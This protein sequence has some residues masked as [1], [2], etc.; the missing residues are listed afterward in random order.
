MDVS[1]LLQRSNR[2]AQDIA[3][4]VGVSRSTVFRW[5]RGDVKPSADNLEALL[6]LRIVRRA[7]FARSPG[8][9]GR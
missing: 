2:S 5:L 1:S 6:R 7:D 3:R 8:Q 4:L 9:G